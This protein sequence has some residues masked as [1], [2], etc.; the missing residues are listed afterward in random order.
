[1]WVCL[2]ACFSVNEKSAFYT[3]MRQMRL[4]MCEAHA[5]SAAVLETQNKA[6]KKLN[7]DLIK[8][9]EVL[10]NLEEIKY[11]LPPVYFGV[12]KL[13]Q[14]TCTLCDRCVCVAGKPHPA[15]RAAQRSTSRTWTRTSLTRSP[16]S[17]SPPRH[18]CRTCARAWRK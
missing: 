1:M 13:R 4:A 5:A 16:S 7:R 8:A 6:R 2:R 15:T 11:T 14:V 10:K 9:K 3:K 18:C 17:S 12:L